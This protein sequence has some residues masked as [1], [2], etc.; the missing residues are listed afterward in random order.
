[1]SP[2]QKHDRRSERVATAHT[3][4]VLTSLSS[5][6]YG[7]CALS[8]VGVQR[9]QHKSYIPSVSTR[10]TSSIIAINTRMFVVEII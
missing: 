1:M 8:A 2:I 10:Y 5:F 9:I 4:A 3:H 6:E 7:V